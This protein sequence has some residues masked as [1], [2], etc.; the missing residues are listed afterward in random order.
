M[1]F[2]VYTYR[3]MKQALNDLRN[4]SYNN[5]EVASSDHS[6]GFKK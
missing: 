3:E 6:Q 4:A 1:S 5:S 2:F